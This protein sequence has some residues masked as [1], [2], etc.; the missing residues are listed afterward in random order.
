MQAIEVYGLNELINRI[1]DCIGARQVNHRELHERIAEQMKDEL[2][3]SI[4]ASGFQN[5]GRVVDWQGEHVG[6]GG[7]YAAV[8]AIKGE[9]G[10]T[11]KKYRIGYLVNALENGHRV[12]P[13]GKTRPRAKQ[14]RVEGYHFYDRTKP[15]LLEIATA[16]AEKYLQEIADRLQG[17]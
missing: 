5:P 15:K 3:A 14:L 17:K 16:E 9:Y 7:G 12:R 13:P 11:R 2:D 4:L 8:R 6:S 10:K 1:D